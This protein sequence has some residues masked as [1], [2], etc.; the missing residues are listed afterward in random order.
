[1]LLVFRAFLHKWLLFVVVLCMQINQVKSNLD[2]EE[3]KDKDAVVQQK[4]SAL[5]E[6]K[7]QL[8]HLQKKKGEVEAS[9]K[10][11]RAKVEENTT[12]MDKL[13]KEV[14]GG[15]G[16]GCLGELGMGRGIRAV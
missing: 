10:K 7:K 8:E 13:Q 6:D 11:V 12:K 2:Y 1:M 15:V 16:R 14:R 4:E 5:E 9:A 3:D